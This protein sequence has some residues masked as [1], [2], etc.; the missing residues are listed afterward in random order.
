MQVIGLPRHV[1]RGAVRWPKGR[2]ATVLGETVQHDTLYCL[3]PGCQA[4]L[5][6]TLET[7]S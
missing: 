5:H 7:S 1:A 4:D 6:S 3:R 2:K